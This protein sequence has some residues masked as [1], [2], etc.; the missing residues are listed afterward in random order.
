M[1]VASDEVM[2]GVHTDLY[3][4]EPGALTSFIFEKELF[5]ADW[6]LLLESVSSISF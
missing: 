6:K 5:R 2:M 4:L 1:F 3:C